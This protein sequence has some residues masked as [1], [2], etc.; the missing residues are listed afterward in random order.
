MSSALGQG[1]RLFDVQD[2]ERMLPLIRVIVKGMMDDHA[3][4]QAL[5]DRL[6]GPPDELQTREARSLRSEIDTLTEKL[7]EAASELENLGVEF[8]GIDPGLIDFPTMI[9]GEL[10]YLCW[11]Y[12]EDRIEYWHS[13]DGGY[14]G[15][16]PLERD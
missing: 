15:R 6:E 7:S 1:I 14:A 10:A 3:E 16:R 12:G 5:L 8:K 13:P 4:R 9:E 11:S 2:A